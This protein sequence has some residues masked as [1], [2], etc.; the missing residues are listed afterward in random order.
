MHLSVPNRMRA[1][2]TAILLFCTNI[3]GLILGPTAV[4]ALTQYVFGNPAAL[5]YS[6]SIVSLAAGTLSVAALWSS[7]RH[8][9][10]LRPPN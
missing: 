2:L 9:P 8:F 5:R 7:L 10:E 4:A 6:L 1:L 3:I